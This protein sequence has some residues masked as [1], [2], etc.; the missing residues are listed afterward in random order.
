MRDRRCD[1]CAA[2]SHTRAPPSHRLDDNHN[3]M[4]RIQT[5]QAQVQTNIDTS[6][7]LL[8][9]MTS[10]MGW[11]AWGTKADKT[12]PQFVNHGGLGGDAEGSAAETQQRAGGRAPTTRS[13]AAAAVAAARSPMPSIRSRR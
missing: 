9:G 12:K 6:N 13:A 11:R 4:R 7:K 1:A 2:A 8:K 10:F 3:Q 5:G